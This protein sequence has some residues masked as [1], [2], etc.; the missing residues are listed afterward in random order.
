MGLNIQNI[1]MTFSL[2]MGIYAIIRSIF[3]TEIPETL[4]EVLS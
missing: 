2:S 3:V 4:P 1:S